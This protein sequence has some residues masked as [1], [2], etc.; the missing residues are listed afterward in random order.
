MDDLVEN[1]NNAYNSC[2]KSIPNNTNKLEIEQNNTYKFIKS[3]QT[4]EKKQLEIGNKV[5][6]V[7]NKNLFDKGSIPKWSSKVY[8]I[9]DNKAHS[10][11]LDND[12]WFK[13]YQLQKVILSDNEIQENK[14]KT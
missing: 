14:K 5:R 9:L 1:I 13:Y 3:I 10:Y 2:I 11:L 6:C 12:K 4:E 8:V 7:V